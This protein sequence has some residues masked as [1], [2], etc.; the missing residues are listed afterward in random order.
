MRVK[1]GAYGVTKYQNTSNFFLK[2]RLYRGIFFN[3]PIPK[4]F[5]ASLVFVYISRQPDLNSF[6]IQRSIKYMFYKN[7]IHYTKYDFFMHFKGIKSV[8]S[9][10]KSKK[11]N[12]WIKY[13]KNENTMIK[14]K[15]G[16]KPSITVNYYCFHHKNRRKYYQH[17]K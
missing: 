11:R 9:M 3:I 4:L 2:L 7:L 15:R 17:T 13:M 16:T 10:H 12:K 1:W 8:A 14:I 6:K 5:P